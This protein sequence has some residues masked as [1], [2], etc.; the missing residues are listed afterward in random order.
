MDKLFKQI[1]KIIIA[2]IDFLHIPFQ[3]W[4][5]SQTFRYAVTGAGN[6]M[7]DWVLYFLVYNFVL[8]HQMLHLGIVTLSS[9]I[10][11][12]MIV[13]PITLLTGF[14]LAR[15]VT[16]TNSTLRG[17]TQLIR[18]VLIV[19]TNLMANY[20]GLKLLVDIWGIYPTPSKMIITV[21][22][23]AFSYLA[24]KYFSFR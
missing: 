18:Y 1:A 6:M 12:L 21:F 23:V 10:A 16:F 22:C 20:V 7:L 9:H 24:Q 3:Q 4:F 11:S 17:T 8:Q 2:C 13:F 14:F 19:G 5:P 15:Y